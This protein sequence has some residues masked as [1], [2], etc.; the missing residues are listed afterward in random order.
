MSSKKYTLMLK[1]IIKEEIRKVV[2]EVMDSHFGDI[3]QK[4]VDTGKVDFD[5]TIE[6]NQLIVNELNVHEEYRNKGIGTYI[7]N[8]IISKSSQL[9]LDRIILNIQDDDAFGKGSKMF[10]IIK[11][12]KDFGFTVTKSN[13]NSVVMELDLSK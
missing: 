8:S 11:F 6:D 4:Y 12:Y 9:G 10:K 2:A 5:A 7:V 3:E 1:D 13:A